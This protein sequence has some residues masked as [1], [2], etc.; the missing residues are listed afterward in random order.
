MTMEKYEKN[1]NI[2]PDT[3]FQT[4]VSVCRL[5]LVLLGI[6]GISILPMVFEIVNAKLRKRKAPPV[7]ID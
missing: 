4:I 2:K 1:R 7:S 6:I 3:L 5:I